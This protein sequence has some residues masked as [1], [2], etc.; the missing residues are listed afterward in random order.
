MQLTISGALA[1]CPG[2][3]C[4][5][6]GTILSFFHGT[7]NYIPTRGILQQFFY[8]GDTY[9]LIVYHVPQA[10]NPL[11]IVKG[12]IPSTSLAHGRYK[13]FVFID[14]QCPGMDLKHSCGSTNWEN[15]VVR[16]YS[17]EA[18]SGP[19][20]DIGT[21]HLAPCFLVYDVEICL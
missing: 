12:V 16:V 17:L 15:R 13:S 10:R 6:R 14:S 19:G 2:I 8:P 4:S 20:N 11:D 5:I 18:L 7:F 1:L 21:V 3:G 9:P